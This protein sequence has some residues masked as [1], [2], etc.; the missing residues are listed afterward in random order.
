MGGPT[1]A[2]VCVD[3]EHSGS[4]VVTGSLDYMIRLY[5]FNGMKSDL[6]PFRWVWANKRC[7]VEAV[8]PSYTQSADTSLVY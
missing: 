5:D 6:R 7:A 8:R 1:K 3:V 4:R 2:V